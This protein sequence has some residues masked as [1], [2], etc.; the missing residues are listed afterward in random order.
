MK[1]I[2]WPSLSRDLPPDNFE[3]K[4]CAMLQGRV[5]RAY[6]FGSYGTDAFCPGS[7]VDLILVCETELPFVERP[8]LFTDLY[9]LYPRLDLLV[10]TCSE[11]KAQL[12]ESTGFWA[13]VK[14]T[15][16]ELPI[17]A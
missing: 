13:S 16:R 12:S 8:R 11:L 15:L 10:Y 9:K 7:D 6:V 3:A 14:A 4:L 1:S 2:V 17:Q 5:E